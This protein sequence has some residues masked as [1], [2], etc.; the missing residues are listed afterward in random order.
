MTIGRMLVIG[1]LMM[2]GLHSIASA[3]QPGASADGSWNGRTSQGRPISFK[4]EAG[5]IRILE[6]DW[7]M[8]LDQVCPG[9]T[10]SSASPNRIERGDMLFFHPKVK[11][12]EPPRVQSSAFVLS[13]EVETPEMPVT[14]GLSG[15]FGSDSTVSGEMTLTTTGCTG[16]ETIKWQAG[17][18]PAPAGAGGRA[19]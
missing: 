17:K 19:Q 4:I 5:A 12:H 18:K 2:G 9:R 8:Q 16:H 1:G 7:M 3:Q 13:S 6:L 11:G 14:V 15:S 10:G